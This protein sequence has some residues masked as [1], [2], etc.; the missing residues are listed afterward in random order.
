VRERLLPA[1]ERLVVVVRL[2]VVRRAVVRPRLPVARF[3]VER[4]P[5]AARRG[6]VLPPLLTARR[7]AGVERVRVDLRVPRDVDFLVVLSAMAIPPGMM[8]L[9]SR[10]GPASSAKVGSLHTGWK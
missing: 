1:R 5:A 8:W 2:V 4:L 3:A 6:V 7:R 10:C 9:R